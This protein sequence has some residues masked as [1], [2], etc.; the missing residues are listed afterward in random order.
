MF[1]RIEWQIRQKRHS[2]YC[3]NEIVQHR[4]RHTGNPGWR[5]DCSN[6][7]RKISISQANQW[8]RPSF[9]SVPSARYLINRITPPNNWTYP[10]CQAIFCPGMIAV[11][12][13][14]TYNKV[15]F[16]DRS[17]A[18]RGQPIVQGPGL[19]NQHCIQ[20]RP[21][22]TTYSN[23]LWYQIMEHLASRNESEQ[24]RDML[25]RVSQEGC[26]IRALSA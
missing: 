8:S 26:M 12:L 23:I 2:R 7:Q 6:D 25:V 19:A 9:L 16:E 17:L 10:F 13:G 14:I 18:V 1:E 24:C 4:P 21:T 3:E 15:T 11:D 5:R 22:D 20:T